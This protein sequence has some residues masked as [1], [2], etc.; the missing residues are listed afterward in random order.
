MV[1]CLAFLRFRK[2]C[3]AAQGDAIALPDFTVF[4]VRAEGG[5]KI[6]YPWL[7]LGF[8]AAMRLRRD[9]EAEIL[10]GEMK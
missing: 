1:K 7:A 10:K 4:S 2:R 6:K 3:F 5:E 8:C 9:K